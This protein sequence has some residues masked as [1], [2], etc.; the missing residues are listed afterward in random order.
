MMPAQRYVTL[1]GFAILTWSVYVQ[2]MSPIDLC[3]RRPIHT[4]APK[5]EGSN[6]FHIKVIGLNAKDTYKP[7]TDYKVIVNGS[8]PDQNLLG[9][10]MV[11]V[12][13]GT[14]EE[15]KTLGNFKL[16][17]SGDSVQIARQCNHTVLIHRFLLPKKGISVVWKAPERGSGC[18]QFRATVIERADAWYKDHGGLT[19]VICEEDYTEKHQKDEMVNDNHEESCCPCNSV[20]YKLIF[21][22]LWSRRTHPKDF[23][24]QTSLLHWSNIVGASHRGD[25][26]IWQ[27]GQYA[28]R[29]V[30]YVCEYGASNV[31]EAE[32]RKHSQQIRSIVKTPQMWGNV[33]GSHQ[34]L[35]TVNKDY[36]YLSLITMIGPSPDWCVGVSALN[37]CQKNCSWADKMEINLYPWDAGTDDGPSYMGP[38]S[39]T[40]PQEKIHEITNRYP[41]SPSSPFYGP[42]KI[43]PMAR[44]TLTKEKE[45]C[46]SKHSPESGEN[47]RTTD[48]LVNLMKKKMEMKKKLEKEKCST[49]L[50]SE[51][52]PCS[53]SCG[54]GSQQRRRTLK[55][56]HV[57]PSMCN[58]K[59]IETKKCF[60]LAV[61]CDTGIKDNNP[62]KRP[63]MPKKNKKHGLRPGKTLPINYE[64]RHQQKMNFE[65]KCAMTPWSPWSPCSVTCGRGM[66]ERWRIFTSKE[67]TPERCRVRRMERDLCVG[68]VF[69]CHKAEMMK[70]WTSVCS[71]PPDDGPCRG[72]FQRWY[73]DLHMSKCAP[74][75]YG[76]CRGNENRFQRKEDC[77]KLCVER[78]E[79]IMMMKEKDKVMMKKQMRKMR[80]KMKKKKNRR[81]R[82]VSNRVNCMVTPWSNWSECSATCGNG[83]TMKSRMIKVKPMNGGRRCPKRMVKKK[84]C[85]LSKCAVHC[86]MTKWGEWSPCSGS[87]DAESGMQVRKRDRAVKP[88]RGGKACPPKIEKKTCKIP[89]CSSETFANSTIEITDME[90]LKK[91]NSIPQDPQ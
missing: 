63:K 48:E 30:K 88:R 3:D 53:A 57:L 90:K 49:N 23:P 60:E 78:M 83:I 64:F 67:A 81:H 51:W 42:D 72:S 37:L 74:F 55:M 29:A 6:G 66:K 35:F 54:M 69:D 40:T 43:P 21:K 36:Q 89:S 76:G 7:G 45:Q 5:R 56:A 20:T 80:K 73:Y 84:K 9:L 44:V 17:D 2:C 52:T 33:L 27:Y 61:G 68:R 75:N 15:Y 8:T 12:P 38:K 79:L 25:Y 39:P 19:K 50:W 24:T 1:V 91:S 41:N 11:V 22:G 62:N 26:N 82:H 31:L 34:A 71:Q 14:V 47:P 32:M 46:G 65:D 87:C 16:R 77:V 70:N 10:M 59:L 86:E 13:N 28:S 4:T 58:L 85:K 18:V